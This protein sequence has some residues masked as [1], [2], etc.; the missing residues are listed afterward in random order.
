MD[1]NVLVGTIIVSVVILI[2]L[3]WLVYDSLVRGSRSSTT[4][5]TVNDGTVKTKEFKELVTFVNK[6]ETRVTKLEK[7]TEEILTDIRGI[8]VRLNSKG[9]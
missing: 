8:K 4:Y 6:M 1:P 5:Y 7:T 9:L 2:I 3:F